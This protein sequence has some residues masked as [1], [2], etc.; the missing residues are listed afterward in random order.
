VV[1][2]AGEGE[3]RSVFN[4]GQS[5]KSPFMGVIEEGTEFSDQRSASSPRRHRWRSE[6]GRTGPKWLGRNGV[7][8]KAAGVDLPET[9]YCT[10]PRSYRTCVWGCGF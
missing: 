4:I 5:L 7:G 2:A 1:A 6:Y 3:Q 8:L 9:G 10:A